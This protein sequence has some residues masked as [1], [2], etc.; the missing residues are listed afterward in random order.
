METGVYL[1]RGPGDVPNIRAR[2]SQ[3]RF[4]PE[5]APGRFSANPIM[6]S[7]TGRT[8]ATATPMVGDERGAVCPKCGKTLPILKTPT[9]LRAEEEQRERE[10]AASLRLVFAG[11]TEDFGRVWRLSGRVGRSEWSKIRPLMRY[12]T[13]ADEAGMDADD[14]DLGWVTPHPEEVERILGITGDRTVAA[15]RVAQEAAR[16]AA[17]QLRE[18]LIR[19]GETLCEQFHGR[20]FFADW[21]WDDYSQCAGDVVAESD[22]WQVREY[23]IDGQTVG[24]CLEAK[25]GNPVSPGDV[26]RGRWEW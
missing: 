7:C 15:Q 22:H 19:E 23:L 20:R 6:C 11:R 17:D 3:G 25:D 26:I 16:V 4:Y 1:L 5:T 9:D 21:S 12:L 13:R 8:A 10:R 18:G 2:F 14:H 24:V